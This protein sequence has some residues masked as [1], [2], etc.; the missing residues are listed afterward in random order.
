MAAIRI[1]YALAKES[2]AGR[3]PLHNRITALLAAVAETG[4][5]AGAAERLGYSYRHV[6]NL[7]NAW[8]KELGISLLERGKGRAG[9]L[10]PAARRWIGAEKEILANYA[11]MLASL[12]ADLERGFE[13]AMNES[14]PLVRLSGCPDEAIQLL[15]Q[16]AV[17]QKFLLEVDF[18]SSIQGLQDLA[19]GRSQIAGF[20]FPVRVYSKAGMPREFKKFFED[21]DLTMLG[22]AMRIQG[23]AVAAGNPLEIHSMLDVSLKKARYI[24]R[25]PGTGTRILCDSLLRASGIRPEEI[26][27]YGEA[28]PSHK[29]VAA[30]V[31]LGKAD[32]GLC[33][34]YAADQEGADF[35]PLVKEAYYLACSCA[36]LESKAGSLFLE[37]LER[38]AWR[39][40]AEK[41]SGYDFAILGSRAI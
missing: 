17:Q 23:L 6:W 32:A 19:A 40:R 28:A 4:S 9:K 37:T 8:E 11:D 21:G 26:Q 2:D 16:D 20:N 12:R 1:E 35:I 22:F 10:T 13:R 34:Q 31:A 7:I 3:S 18:N 41:L 14:L 27:G 36:F 39:S 29:S 5:L 38:G 25:A 15:R 33:I 30:Q 24:N